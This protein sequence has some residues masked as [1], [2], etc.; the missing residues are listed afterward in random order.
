MGPWVHSGGGR[1]GEWG[2]RC[3]DKVKERRTGVHVLHKFLDSFFQHFFTFLM[4]NCLG[5]GGALSFSSN[6]EL[7]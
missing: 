6:F 2:R 3:F 7:D 5:S 4:N 1:L